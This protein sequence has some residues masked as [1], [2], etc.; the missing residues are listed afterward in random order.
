M[1][2]IISID[3]RLIAKLPPR[4][5]ASRLMAYPAR[6]RL[7]LILERADAE[8]VVAA[9]PEQDFYLSVKELGEQNGLPLLALA[10]TEQ[11]NHLLDIECWRREEVVAG[12]ALAQLEEI[13]VANGEKFMAW[14][15]Q[16][17]F[18]LLVVLFKKWMD[19]QL[20]EDEED[21]H[22]SDLPPH[23][24]DGQYYFSLKYLF[25]SH[26][27]FYLELL[28]HV[29][30]ALDTEVAELAYQFHH[31]RLEDSGIP[32]FHDARTIYRPLQPEKIP[33]AAKGGFRP[34][35]EA[36]AP[37]FALALIQEQSLLAAAMALIEEPPLRH[38]L[39]IELATLANKILIADELDPAEAANLRLAAEKAGAYLNLG[40]EET[41][42][43]DVTRAAAA[44]RGFYLEDLFRLAHTRINQLR[45]RLLTLLEKGWLSRWPHGLHLLD[46]EWLE[47]ASM[48]LAKT[49][50]ILRQPSD[51]RRSAMEDFI[52]SKADLHQAEELIATIEAL[53]SLFAA[54]E[55]EWR[56]DWDRL[57]LLLWRQGQI[58]NL[59][60]VTLG[61]FLLTAAANQVAT[62]SWQY[63]PLPVS[64]WPTIFPLLTPARL[65]AALHEH[66]TELLADKNLLA[67]AVDYLDP[68]LARYRTETGSFGP[69]QLPDP[70]L[71]PFFLFTA[72]P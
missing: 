54:I 31:G 1:P 37:T 21:Y 3:D 65:E 9:M 18:E 46:Q 13:A 14:L 43:L 22:R 36:G 30:N 62:G 64:G 8:E 28:T 39:Q 10:K 32:D 59:R 38:V 49:P 2:K 23:T 4:E 35:T 34:D 25:E 29:M 40:L 60:N 71:V 5:L 45:S 24:L 47:P 6:K 70:E 20:I 67:K 63:A 44:L 53:H 72:K 11:L 68:V 16:A 19:V 41:T 52:R 57:E 15:Y 17:D 51:D 66:L 7:D 42:A 50:M 56:R 33:A 69:G 55:Q 27:E 26:R 58:T 48:L 61:N 12:K